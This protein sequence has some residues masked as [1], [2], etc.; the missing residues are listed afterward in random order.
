MYIS[1][2]ELGTALGKD[3]VK[4]GHVRK[5]WSECQREGARQRRCD[6]EFRVRYRASIGD[7]R[8]EV[9]KALSRWMTRARARELMEKIAAKLSKWHQEI[10]DLN[11]P[12]NAPMRILGAFVYRGSDDAWRVIDV[13]LSAYMLFS[14]AQIDAGAR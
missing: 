7:F 12:N 11:Y 9:E 10:T 2:G 6:I 4:S 3:I 8:R 5:A 13:S 14:K 1:I